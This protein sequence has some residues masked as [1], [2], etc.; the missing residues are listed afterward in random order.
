MRTVVTNGGVSPMSQQ[1]FPKRSIDDSYWS[2]TLRQC[3][4][5]ME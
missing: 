5:Y 3:L 1:C 2:W 4:V